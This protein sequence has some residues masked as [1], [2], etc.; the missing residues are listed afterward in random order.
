MVHARQQENILVYRRNHRL[1]QL[2]THSFSRCASA[3]PSS[4]IPSAALRLTRLSSARLPLVPVALDEP[5]PNPCSQKRGVEEHYVTF[6]ISKKVFYTISKQ[7]AP[8]NLGTLLKRLTKGQT[9]TTDGMF[10][11]K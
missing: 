3:I 11:P 9:P 10:G 5:P 6:Q 4:E 1:K 7:F 2:V 8:K